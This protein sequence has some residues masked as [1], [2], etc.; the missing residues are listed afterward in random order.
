MNNPILSIGITS[1]KRVE[2]LIRCIKSIETQYG[3]DIEIIVSED[4]S[5][6][7]KEIGE[8]V[9]ALKKDCPYMLQGAFLY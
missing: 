3:D 7:S 6:L 2:E 4:C 8:R 9:E 1:Y 5:P